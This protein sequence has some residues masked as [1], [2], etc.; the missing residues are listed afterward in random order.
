MWGRYGRGMGEIWAR[1]GGGGRGLLEAGRQARRELE[2]AAL[3][4]GGRVVP[5][6][7]LAEDELLPAGL[8]AVR[9]DRVQRVPW[10]GLGLGL[11][12][13]LGIGVGVGLG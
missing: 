6:L 3:V 13:G 5:Q 8:L 7:L 12:S 4:V 2:E 9:E 11:W 1:Y 10:L